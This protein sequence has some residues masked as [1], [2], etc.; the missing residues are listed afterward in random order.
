[1]WYLKRLG[2]LL[3]IIVCLPLNI[4]FAEVDLSYIKIHGGHSK[5]SNKIDGDIQSRS[6]ALGGLGIGYY[7][8]DNVRVELMLSRLFNPMRH[9]VDKGF[10]VAESKRNLTTLFFS[11]YFDI[12]DYS[13]GK[14]FLGTGVGITRIDGNITGIE[15]ASGP[16]AK[17]IKTQNNLS[18]YFSFWY[19]H[20]Y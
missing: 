13:F 14:V 10:L 20:T 11:G 4:V 5:I 17:K 15:Y 19:Y 12:L 9:K 16:L 6:F 2:V 3:T 8:M 1:M 18:F 7:V